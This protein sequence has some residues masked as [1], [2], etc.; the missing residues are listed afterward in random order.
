MREEPA[1]NRPS[2]PP[3]LGAV[4]LE[5]LL[6]RAAKGGRPRGPHIPMVLAQC[7]RLTR[8]FV[9]HMQRRCLHRTIPWRAAAGAREAP[10]RAG[11]HGPAGNTLEMSLTLRGSGF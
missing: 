6:H 8:L 11:F 4:H 2:L 9:A 7:R 1:E 3:G 5:Y 10:A